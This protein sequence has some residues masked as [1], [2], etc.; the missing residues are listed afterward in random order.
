M[1]R[2]KPSQPLTPLCRIMLMQSESC[3]KVLF[4][5]VKLILSTGNFINPENRNAVQES[6]QGK[7]LT[8]DGNFLL[9]FPTPGGGRCFSTEIEIKIVTLI[10]QLLLYFTCRSSLVLATGSVQHREEVRVCATMS[11]GPSQQGTGGLPCLDV[12]SFPSQK[13]C[14]SAQ[15]S[16]LPLLWDGVRTAV[17]LAAGVSP[18]LPDSAPE[19]CHSFSH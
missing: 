14:A 9:S 4:L 8:D 11:P 13:S 2:V 17:P 10:F 3:L 1:A 19:V 5:T 12:L 15:P 18:A 6:T 7:C 16:W